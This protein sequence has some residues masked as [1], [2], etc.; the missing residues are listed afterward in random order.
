MKR[1]A[2]CAAFYEDTHTCGDLAAVKPEANTGPVRPVRPSVR[3]AKKSDIERYRDRDK[4]RA[5][6]RTY[7][8]EHM[9]IQRA[10]LKSATPTI[11]QGLKP[12]APRRW[13]S[14]HRVTRTMRCYNSGRAQP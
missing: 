11:R 9:R 10:E 5:Y 4:R 2:L 14:G 6:L 7:M 12:P 8:R 1:C 3:P 13:E